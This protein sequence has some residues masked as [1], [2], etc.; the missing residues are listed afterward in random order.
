[1]KNKRPFWQF[2]WGYKESVVFV[3][4]IA[5]AGFFLQAIAGEF[6]FI[7]LQYPVN[8][9]LGCV[10]LFFLLL[11][12]LKRKSPLYQWFSGT[13]MAVALI[14]AL[15][16]LSVIMGLI[17]QVQSSRAPD[18]LFSRLG[19]TR[20]TSAWPFVL[21]Y[22]LTLLSL[23]A[24]IIR[25][26]FKFRIRDYAFYL[27]HIGLWLL[28]F[29]AG[30]GA[31]DVRRY[32]MYVNKG[33]TEWRVYNSRGDA[34]ELPVAIELNDFYMEE[35]PP[36]LAVIDRKTGVPQPENRPE[37][38]QIDEAQAN[39]Q[40]AGWD[41]SLK[42]YIR[43]AMRSS[44]SAYREARMPGASPAAMV[45]I[46]HPRTGVQ[47]N[48]WV[49]AGN[50]VQLYMVLDLDEQY[51]LAMT[52]P[53]PK[54]FVS[55]I[56]IYSE[57]GKQAHTLLEVNKPYKMGHWMLYQYGYDNNAGN[58][59]AY[60]G[61]ELVYDP[62]LIPVYAGMLLLACGSLCMLRMGNKRKEAPDDME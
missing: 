4:G 55:D 2:P 18:N 1:M 19:F 32:V 15:V 31:S 11:F 35:Y 27:N 56:N 24:V 43:E 53:E 22:F 54:R 42:K 28:L 52:R 26:L 25:R 40:I 41:I 38:F 12:S 33:E 45:E 62:W 60:S 51:C 47:K 30:A 13:P 7:L 61:I 39:G 5:V 29:A 59:S 14:G 49:C 21:I 16:V 8:I 58:M 50:A 36:Q 20:V 57:D 48:G 23:G 3:A 46:S 44:E 10:T 37:Y 9:I 17:P 6:D 34:L